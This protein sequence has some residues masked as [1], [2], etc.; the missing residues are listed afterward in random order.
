MTKRYIEVA[1]QGK[2]DWWRYIL[3][4]I[5]PLVILFIV[6]VVMVIVVG[7]ITF[8]CILIAINF[9][10]FPRISREEF[11]AL[12]PTPV[13][14]GLLMM[15]VTG[16][17]MGVYFAITKLHKRPF[18]SIVSAEETFHAKRL[19]QAMGLWLLLRCGY[20][21]FSH[22]QNPENWQL[23]FNFTRWLEFLPLTILY[24]LIFGSV[25]AIYLIGYPLQMIS[26]FI[27][28]PIPIGVFCGICTAAIIAFGR[29][30]S[31]SIGPVGTTIEALLSFLLTFAWVMIILK[32]NRLELAAGVTAADSLYSGGFVRLV[33]SRPNIFYDSVP[34]IWKA[35][36]IE[37]LLTS[38]PSLYVS[39]ILFNFIGLGILYYVF[40]RKP[41]RQQA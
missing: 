32:D 21:T 33:S 35:H 12:I 5:I 34:S 37:N 25:L 9:T 30:R 31:A 2:N 24:S 4:S 18:L 7:V 20:G 6:M 10:D 27:R 38:R 40:L 19:F 36:P 1:R 29:S 11:L 8:V 15:S 14:I 23:V 26:L 28:R 17:G 22:S 41:D 16:A 39:W 3:G 13:G